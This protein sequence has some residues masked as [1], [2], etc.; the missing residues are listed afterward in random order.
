LKNSAAGENTCGR[1]ERKSR[2]TVGIQRAGLMAR[3]N[4]GPN[5]YP[6]PGEESTGWGKVR[7]KRGN[8]DSQEGQVDSQQQKRSEKKKKKGD[9]KTES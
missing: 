6:S 1:K 7:R 8:R 3:L 2:E 5:G 9:T 4:Q